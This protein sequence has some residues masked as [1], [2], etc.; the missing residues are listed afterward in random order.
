ME[1][2]V[3]LVTLGVR[4]LGRALAFYRDGLGWPLSS[5]SVAGQIAFLRTGGIVLTLFSREALAEDANV[6][7]EGDGFSGFALAHNVAER[8]QVD[9]MLTEAV[10][11]GATIVRPAEDVVFGR[12]GYFADPDGHLWEVAWNPAFRM[13]EDGAIQLPN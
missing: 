10:Y 1:P 13:G 6:S 11:A 4:D 2:M 12:R 3:S 9:V 8:E 7:S 5:A